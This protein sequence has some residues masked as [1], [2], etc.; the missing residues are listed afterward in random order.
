MNEMFAM[1]KIYEKKYG[2]AQLWVPILAI[3]TIV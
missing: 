2:V 3:S 1:G